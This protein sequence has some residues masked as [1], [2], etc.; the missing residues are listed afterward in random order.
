MGRLAQR[1]P[2]GASTGAWWPAHPG[3]DPPVWAGQAGGAPDLRSPQTHKAP[4]HSDHG[5]RLPG[6]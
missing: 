2:A 1:L 4:L 3:G 5:G 6:G